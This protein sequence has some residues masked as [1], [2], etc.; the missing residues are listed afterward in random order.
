MRHSKDLNFINEHFCLFSNSNNKENP[1]GSL[2]DLNYLNKDNI[3]ENFLK[4]I[5]DNNSP[6]HSYERQSQFIQ[7]NKQRQ[8]YLKFKLT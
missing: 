3:N 4:A 8:D 1:I 2:I 6:Y 7:T 5:H